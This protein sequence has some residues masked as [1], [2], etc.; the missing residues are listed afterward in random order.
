[1]MR[2]VASAALVA[3]VGSAHADVFNGGFEE[4]DQGFRSVQPGQTWGGWTC[5]GPSDIEFVHAVPNANLNNL[6][7]SAYEGEYWIDLCGV[8]QPSGI[9]QDIADLS[10]GDRYN[11]SF[12]QAGN[13]WGPSFNFIMNV[14]WN[15]QVVATFSSVHGG[16]DGA[17]MGWQIREVEV[18]AQDGTNRLEFRAVTATSARGA[19]IDAV[20]MTLV[21]SPGVLAFMACGGLVGSRRKRL[22]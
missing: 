20:S 15:G 2:L 16:S 7:F 6:Q 22:A 5:S 10:G 3:I 13:V 17:N 21:P 9:Y 18:V 4:P 1:M 12:A 14:V 19:A 11:I 8:G